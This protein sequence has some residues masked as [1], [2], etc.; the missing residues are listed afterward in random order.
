MAKS[1]ARARALHEQAYC[2]GLPDVSDIIHTA[3]IGEYQR[4]DQQRLLTVY[5]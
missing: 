4:P 5:P 2:R 1:D 3:G